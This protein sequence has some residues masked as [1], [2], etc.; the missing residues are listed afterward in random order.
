MLIKYEGVVKIFNK[1][2]TKV[3]FEHF[4]VC[5]IIFEHDKV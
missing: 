4:L 2:L 1:I 3:T 5:Y